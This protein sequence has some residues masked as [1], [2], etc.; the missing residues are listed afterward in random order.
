[1]DDFDPYGSLS[2]QELIALL[3][4][5]DRRIK[6]LSKENAEDRREI[7]SLGLDKNINQRILN[8][9]RSSDLA[10]RLK[11]ILSSRIA[12]VDC[13]ALARQVFGPNNSARLVYILEADDPY[14]ECKGK[15][16]VRDAT[17]SGMAMKTGSEQYARRSDE[18]PFNHV[19][20]YVAP[21]ASELAIPIKNLDDKSIGVI[22]LRKDGYDSFAPY[23]DRITKFFH[24]HEE[25]VREKLLRYGD[26]FDSE[27]QTLLNRTYGHFL[28]E[29]LYKRTK[30][31]REPFTVCFFDMDNFKRVNEQLGHYRADEALF[32]FGLAFSE[33]MR[34]SDIFARHKGDQFTL[35]FQGPMHD[36]HRERLERALKLCGQRIPALQRE[37][38]PET[39]K[40]L[41]LPDDFTITLSGGYYTFDPGKSGGH[42]RELY[43]LLSNA[44]SVLKRAK[45]SKG[46]LV[47]YQ[48]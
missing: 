15:V 35:A 31:A 10:D 46:S 41:L 45:E 11:D 8:A 43:D 6:T 30:D 9:R 37:F 1:M 4:D 36:E 20:D 25:A 28:M 17:L 21:D 40:K 26:R 32:W 7:G 47:E 27:C 18:H 3:N 34:S 13:V 5:R 44:E 29:E 2:H 16:F 48:G 19:P 42:F 38:S 39:D 24:T 33:E 12:P 14:R 22:F 23:R